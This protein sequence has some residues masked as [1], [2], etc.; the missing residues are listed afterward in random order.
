MAADTAYEVCKHLNN[1]GRFIGIDQDE[2]AIEAA[3][4]RLIDF[5]GESY[6]SQKQLCDMKS[7]LQELGIDKV[8]GIVLDLGVVLLSTGYGRTGIFLSGRCSFGHE[9]G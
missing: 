1:K 6:D 8:D 5:G 7:K 3:G 2:A 4:S 9:N